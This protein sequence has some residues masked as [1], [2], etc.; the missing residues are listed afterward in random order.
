MTWGLIVRQITVFLVRRP[1][2]GRLETSLISGIGSG[3]G[4]MRCGKA[5]TSTGHEETIL[6]EAEDVI[7]CAKALIRSTRQEER[8][9]VE[10]EVDIV[11]EKALVKST[12]HEERV[13]G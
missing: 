8:I 4:L 12:G 7:V 10:V 9:F 6:V 1:R 3:D 13:S 5:L 11:C 2:G